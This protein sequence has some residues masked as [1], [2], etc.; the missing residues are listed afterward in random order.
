M[1]YDK[2]LRIP[3]MIR[4]RTFSSSRV[5]YKVRVHFEIGLD[6]KVH[7]K[8]TLKSTKYSTKVHTKLFI[9]QFHLSLQ[10]LVSY[11][12]RFYVGM[13][14]LYPNVKL[15][16]KLPKLVEKRSILVKKSYLKI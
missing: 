3:G 14:F 5:L 9:Q 11:P 15:C 1:E 7:D 12:L 16:C 4:G 8:S 10:L 13:D 6:D 2:R